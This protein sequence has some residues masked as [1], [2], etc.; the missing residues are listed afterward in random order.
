MTIAN[1][2]ALLLLLPAAVL[3]AW[4]YIGRGPSG[5]RLPGHWHRA[6]ADVMQ[7]F[8]AERVISQNRVPILFWLAVWTLLVLSLARPV[9][10][11]GAPT[12][13]GNL[14]G[15]VIALDLGTGMDV[16]GQRLM[17]Y[18]IF[19]AA[20]KTPTALVVSTG[21]AFDVV[22]LTTDRKQLERYIQVASGDV[23]PVAGRAPGIAI[24]QAEKLLE[25]AE[26]IVGQLV[27]LTGGKVPAAP[28]AKGEKWLRAL[29][30]DSGSRESWTGYAEQVG[31]R[32]VDETSVD[33]V[34]EDLDDR[35]ASALRDTNRSGDMPLAPWLLAAAGLLWL[36]FF[37]R[38]RSA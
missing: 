2:L 1:P 32:L 6:I 26:V 3:V 31:A 13:Y 36:L 10:H 14:A 19:D 38:V 30:V 33:Q 17:A 18:R 11:A 5:L 22:P 20:P 37:R 9:I 4:L 34:I 28:A 8:M 27:V 24:I 29:V 12:E 16:E 7:P 25:R 15:R 21:E 23:M 35:V